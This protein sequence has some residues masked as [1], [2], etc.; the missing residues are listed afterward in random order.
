[1]AMHTFVLEFPGQVRSN[2]WLLSA[3]GMR[4]LQDLYHSIPLAERIPMRPLLTLADIILLRYRP[5][6]PC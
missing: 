2:C 6:S 1:M 4:T 3:T 5:F